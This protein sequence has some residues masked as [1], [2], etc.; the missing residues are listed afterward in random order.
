[1]CPSLDSTHPLL[2]SAALERLRALDPDGGNRLL[3]RVLGAF[4]GS[5]AKLLPRLREAGRAGDTAG[6]RYVAHTLKS[7][8]ASV[9][10]LRLSRLCAEL[11][12]A[13]RV[14]AADQVDALLDEL[15]GEAERLRD[16]L[17]REDST[18]P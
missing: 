15:I 3:G 11:E 13:L 14:E 12:R 6:I 1:M 2:D 7:S 17:A 16:A 10:A 4:H 8:A 18:S 9:G 5:L